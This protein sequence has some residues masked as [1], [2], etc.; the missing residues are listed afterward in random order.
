VQWRA[1]FAG[2]NGQSPSLT[3]VTL[4]Y[5]PQNNPPMVRSIN[6]MTQVAPAGSATKTTTPQT[7]TAATY[8][9]TVTDTGEPGA[10]TLTGTPTQTVARGMTQQIQLV[11]QADDPD[12]DK[13]IYAVY[14]RGEEESQW[15]L[16]RTNFAENMLTLE[17]DVLADGKYLFRVVASDKQAN[18]AAAAREAE[19][20]S[21][22]V[23]F[24]NTPPIVRASAT[25][26][27]ADVEVIVDAEDATSALRR[28][29][30]SLDAAAWIPLDS[31]DGVVDGKQERFTLRIGSLS[32]GEHLIV[33]RAFDA[34]SNAG[35]AKVVVQ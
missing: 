21:A 30:Y 20:V 26:Q 28:A 33:V 16:L 5:L 24:D 25:R 14:F 7:S 2:D 3:G 10:S 1:E 11:W 35:L 12:N 17:G 6:V 15:K 23:L 29:E 27:G 22:P 9:V 4:S 32:P 13:L 8:S 19:L 31:I 34:S 18:S